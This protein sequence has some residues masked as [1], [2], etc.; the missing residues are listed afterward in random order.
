MSLTT[1]IFTAISPVE[2]LLAIKFL[3]GYE[4][5]IG[6]LLIPKSQKVWEKVEKKKDWAP[7]TG[8]PMKFTTL[9]NNNIALAEMIYILANWHAKFC[10]YKF[11]L[12]SNKKKKKKKWKKK[13][14]F[15]TIISS[16]RFYHLTDN[17]LFNVI[18]C[19]TEYCNLVINLRP[20]GIIERTFQ[21]SLDPSLSHA[22]HT[23]ANVSH[24]FKSCSNSWRL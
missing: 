21:V 17:M 22:E 2:Y 9:S 24:Y 12:T 14:F 1:H 11:W 10:L 15:K 3:M 7:L 8:S 6:H 19:T 16:T 18:A 23:G 4:K 20:E 5:K 13:S